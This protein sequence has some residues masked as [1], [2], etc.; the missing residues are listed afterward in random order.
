MTD[1]HSVNIPII[2]N[3]NLSV[4]LWN[5]SV[6][7]PMGLCEGSQS[8]SG[9]WLTLTSPACFF[10]YQK[11]CLAIFSSSWFHSSIILYLSVRWIL[12]KLVKIILSF[13]ER[14]M[15][16]IYCCNDT[17]SGR[18]INLFSCSKLLSSS[19]FSPL[20][21]EEFFWLHF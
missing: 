15:A 17:F 11:I 4:S 12:H 7:S 10:I 13:V 3:F 20:M 5:F 18:L 16:V 9:Q 6:S 21:C 19:V 1:W 2:V 14:C 8:C